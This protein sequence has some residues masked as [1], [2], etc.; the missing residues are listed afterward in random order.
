MKEKD[1]EVILTTFD[2]AEGLR[3]PLNELGKL[4]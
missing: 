4:T 1:K 3:M 2:G